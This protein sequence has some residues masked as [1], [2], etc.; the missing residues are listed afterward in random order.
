[1]EKVAEYLLGK[2]DEML[3]ML[4]TMVEMETPSDNKRLV[5]IFGEKVVE[6]IQ[7]YVQAKVDSIHNEEFGNQVRI[8]IGE[9]DEQILLL[10]H[11]DTVWPEGTLANMP[12]KV[13]GDEAY[14]PGTFDMKGGLVQ[15]I[16]AL[17]ALQKYEVVLTKKIVFLL[18]SDEEIGSDSSRHLIEEEAAKS[19]CV[20]VLESSGALEGMYKTA[21][22]GVGIFDV[23]VKGKAAHAGI[24][25]EKGISAIE[26]LSKIVLYL[27]SLTDLAKGTTVNV[28]VI[29][30][31]SSSNVVAASASA[32]VDL[33]VEMDSEFDRVIP[34]IKNIQPSKEGIQVEVTGDINRP[35]M[36]KTEEVG[37]LFETA[38][39][40]AAEYLDFDLKE[41]LSGGGSD[42]SFASR[43][44]PTLDGM[45]PVGDGA[46]A[47]NEHLIISKMPVRS[48]LLALMLMEAGK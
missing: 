16:F 2:Q 17:H 26:E 38:K 31:G 4:K 29:N 18:V 24:E 45:G 42:G 30:G 48:A 21:R 37:R 44:A 39:H 32:E 7:P 8:E 25:P 13:V 22:K 11:M 23:A 41:Q 28:G 19:S 40:L 10:G 1:M 33:R 5:D 15:G 43:F 9:G 20:F 27:H 6:L 14:G 3:D 12:F 47:A 34:L 35:V 36:E 46:H